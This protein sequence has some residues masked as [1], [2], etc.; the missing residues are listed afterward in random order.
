[1]TSRTDISLFVELLM[2]AALAFALMLTPLLRGIWPVQVIDRREVGSSAA[3]AATSLLPAS[4]SRGAG[5]GGDLGSRDTL[6]GSSPAHA[7][8]NVR[9]TIFFVGLLGL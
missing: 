4:D 1:M 8:R 2:F 5:H 9:A 7:R 6:V 3:A